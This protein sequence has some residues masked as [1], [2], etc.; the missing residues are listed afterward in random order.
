MHHLTIL[1][2]IAAALRAQDTCALK[3]LTYI[4]APTQVP[5]KADQYAIYQPAQF[6]AS[7]NGSL[8][9]SERNARRILEISPSGDLR[10]VASNL[11]FPE[12]IAASADGTVYFVEEGKRLFRVGVDGTIA[13]LAP[14]NSFNSI[15]QLA[16]NASGHLYVLDGS[17]RVYRLSDSGQLEALT[18][19]LTS[20][21]AIATIS[22]N[23]LLIR[24]A[25]G[26]FL[27]LDET[28]NVSEPPELRQVSNFS[29]FHSSNDAPLLLAGN[30]IYSYFPGGQPNS[31]SNLPPSVADRGRLGR[32][33]SGEF[34][35]FDTRSAF[36]AFAAGAVTRTLVP[37]P[38]AVTFIDQGDPSLFLAGRPL[39]IPHPTGQPHFLRDNKLFRLVSGQIAPVPIANDPP[40]RGISFNDDGKLYI[41]SA[42]G[43]EVFLV[44]PDGSLETPLAGKPW[45]GLSGAA[46]FFSFNQLAASKGLLYQL[47]QGFLNVFSLSDGS[48]SS[49]FNPASELVKTFDGGVYSF[50]NAIG[51]FQIGPQGPVSGDFEFLPQD[52]SN[53]SV[54]LGASVFVAGIS[55]FRRDGDGRWHRLR[56]EF[57]SAPAIPSFTQATRF[58]LEDALLLYDSANLA[59]WTLQSPAG[60]ASQPLPY[61]PSNGRL[62]SAA[63]YGDTDSIS[64]NSLVSVF[65]GAMDAGI[66]PLDFVRRGDAI[67]S[68]PDY[69]TFGFANFNSLPSSSLLPFAVF[70]EQASFVAS[71]SDRDEEIAQPLYVILQSIRYRYPGKLR[72]ARS[73]PGLFVQGGFK[74]GPAAALNQDSSVNSSTNPAAP[75]S[76]VALYGTGFGDFRSGSPLSVRIAGQPSEILYSGQAPGLITGLWQI[77]VRL[78]QGLSSGLQPIEIEA[79]GQKLTQRQSVGVHLR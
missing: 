27:L 53:R 23:R 74:D 78:P 75:G 60:C 77:N 39:L 10:I 66:A 16:L 2:L 6:A 34:L 5:S 46:S 29:L 41:Y 72:S 38:P 9:V 7:P 18:S 31:I 47:G 42:T 1:L 67:L 40:I 28:G 50:Q 26:G 63:S 3:P 33:P 8:F 69:P 30:T 54:K 71:A 79:A 12:A 76:I 65:A 35:A 37:A 62:V 14:D 19:S 57:G 56:L 36:V 43:S 13:R 55:L 44:Q 25:S 45:A 61:F 22:R 21:I 32:L 59:L 51:A 73:A 70:P 15:T 49:Y 20:P 52:A 24:R 4:P 48:S 11:R 68:H 58:G 17:I 64:P